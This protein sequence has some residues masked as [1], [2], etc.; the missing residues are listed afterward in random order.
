MS[1]FTVTATPLA[2]LNIIERQRL[3]DSRGFFSRLFCVD[4]L[5]VHGWKGPVAQI[6]QSRTVR[7]GT[8]RGMHFQHPPHSETKLVCCL[9]GEVWDVAVDIRTGSP[10]FLRWHGLRLSAEN[11]LALL[12]PAGFA[13][14]FQALSENAVL[15]YCHS[16]AYA[17][18]SE[19]GLNPQDPKLA[20][21]WPLPLAEI[22]ARDL[23]HPCIDRTFTG[24]RP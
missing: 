21:D 10:T 24:V 17:A 8:I 12:I 5:S 14:G 22:S 15:L 2:G 13:H 11:C 18:G 7:Q 19:G 1:R 4:E 3:A 9:E 20:I 23:A 6:N 16:A